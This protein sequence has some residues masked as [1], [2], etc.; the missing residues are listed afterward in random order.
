MK[1]KDAG[2][3]ANK[4]VNMKL[5]IPNNK[6]FEPIM[7]VFLWDG[8][9]GKEDEFLGFGSIRYSDFKS[10]KNNIFNLE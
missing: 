8:T 5:N 7:D 4:V 1:V 9:D 6:S 3:N 2:A 10:K